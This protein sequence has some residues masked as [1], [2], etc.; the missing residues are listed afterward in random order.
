M[1]TQTLNVPAM[2]HAAFLKAELDFLETEPMF[3]DA[4]KSV[5]SLADFEHLCHVAEDLLKACSRANPS[6]HQFRQDVR[7]ESFTTSS[8]R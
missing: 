7:Y 6:A 8:W 3:S 4:A 5:Q 2:L 1:Q